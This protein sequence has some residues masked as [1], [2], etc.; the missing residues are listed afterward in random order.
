[1]S[2]DAPEPQA[3][4]RRAERAVPEP[5]PLLP[6]A[7]RLIASGE[8][9]ISFFR[10]ATKKPFA[11]LCEPISNSWTDVCHPMYAI[12]RPAPTQLGLHR[13]CTCL[14]HTANIPRVAASEKIP[15]AK[16]QRNPD[17]K[18]TAIPKKTD[19]T[20]STRAKGRSFSYAFMWEMQRA[21][22]GTS[23]TLVS[24]RGG[25]S[26]DG[27]TAETDSVVSG[28][29]PQQGHSGGNE[30]MLPDTATLIDLANNYQNPNSLKI[31]VPSLRRRPPFVRGIPILLE[32]LDL[33]ADNPTNLRHENPPRFTEP[34]FRGVSKGRRDSSMAVLG[35]PHGPSV[36]QKEGEH[37]P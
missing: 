30:K 11:N 18:A 26:L 25:L 23:Q 15:I 37:E 14:N 9:F 2:D 32:I 35:V 19:R 22:Y 16:P 17:V 10:F 8:R 6:V 27:L 3:R 12:A 33:K 7:N 28:V 36:L 29:A 4:Y 34:S 1:M 20:V 31:K 21:Q 24:V 13:D 5:T